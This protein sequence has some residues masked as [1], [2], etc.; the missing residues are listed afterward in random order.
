MQ[1][2]Y[3]FEAHFVF[4]QPLL[5]ILTKRCN[6]CTKDL[7]LDAFSPNSV[8]KDGYTGRCKQCR[9]NRYQSLS[10]EEKERVR[11]RDRESRMPRIEQRRAYDRKR[12]PAKHPIVQ[13]PLI[14][15]SRI[16]LTCGIEKSLEEDFNKH[17]NGK[18]GYRAQCKGCR[19]KQRK[20]EPPR[21]EWVEVPSKMCPR[22]NIEK[23]IGD[24]A[25]NKKMRDGHAGH[26]SECVNQWHR[27]EE[28]KV[29]ERMYR[30][31]QRRDP[32]LNRSRQKRQNQWRRE[33]PESQRELTMRRNARKKAATTERVSYKRILE[34]DGYWCYICERPIDKDAQPRSPESLTFDHVLPIQSRPDELQGAHCEANIKPSHK[35]CNARKSNK[36]LEALTPFDRSGP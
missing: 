5:F 16:C 13:L 30:K 1:P 18:F 9:N 35:V 19:S 31:E 10:E 17:A 34:R 23:P 15:L 27:S 14:P 4:N 28:F 8:Q 6:T 7:S 26:C 3:T 29:Y 20:A 12:R 22:C 32:V 21:Q 36:P 24:F 11:K 33:H 25:I 2:V